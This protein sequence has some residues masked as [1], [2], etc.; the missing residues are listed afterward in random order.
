MKSI[1]PEGTYLTAEELVDLGVTIQTMGAIA[2]FFN[3]KRNE[4]GSS[5]LPALDE[6]AF[7]LQSY[8][9]LARTIV[10]V[11]DR[12]GN[13]KDNASPELADIRHRLGQMNG[14]INSVMRRVI[15]N[16]VKDGYLESDTTASVRDGRLVIRC[17]L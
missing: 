12:W 7:K 14:V 15:A 2:S 8:P 13:I 4:D 6:I 16:A 9:A 17:C 11:V 5:P 3:S 10:R 1:R